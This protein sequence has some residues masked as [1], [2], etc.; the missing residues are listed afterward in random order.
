[1][2]A[3]GKENMHLTSGIDASSTAERARAKKSKRARTSFDPHQLDELHATFQK[4][5]APD[6]TTIHTLSETT[7]LSNRT[8]QVWFQ[9]R[10]AKQRKPLSQQ[11]DEHQDTIKADQVKQVQ[12]QQHYQ[13]PIYP[14]VTEY[15]VQE[16]TQYSIYMD[17]GIL[18]QQPH[19]LTT[20]SSLPFY[21][22]SNGN[23]HLGSS[24]PPGPEV[25]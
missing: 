3:D 20:F 1:M 5:P 16:M 13:R 14:K 12:R 17:P 10:R 22:A 25:L 2:D 21:T 19:Q 18:I 4:N 11:V 15:Y 6:R 23:L 24:S 7:G 9:N 8:I